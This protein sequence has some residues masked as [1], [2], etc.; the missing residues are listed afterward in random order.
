MLTRLRRWRSTRPAAGGV[1]L[2]ASGLF[3]LLPA[4][5]TLHVGDL[6][7][8]ITSIAGVSTV[9]LGALM[10]LCSAAVLLRP[11]T[12]VPAGVSAVILAL[13]ALPA[14][15]FGGF[16]AGTVLG[17]VGAAFALSWQ[18]IENPAASARTS[19]E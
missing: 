19:T 1:L 6:L 13:V 7:I 12:R 8:T 11:Q 3:L 18:Q 16:L 9:L 4:L 14:A 5:T 17:I 2:G 15:N 10:L